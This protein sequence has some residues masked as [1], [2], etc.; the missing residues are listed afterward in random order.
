MNQMI[1]NWDRLQNV[2]DWFIIPDKE[3][4]HVRSS[5]ST[6]VLRHL[7]KGSIAITKSTPEGTF[8]ALAYRPDAHHAEIIDDTTVDP[9]EDIKEYL[10]DGDTDPYEELRPFLDD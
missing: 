6:Y 10:V 9:D 1:Y 2:G 7:P 4:I 8:V 5:L 3:P